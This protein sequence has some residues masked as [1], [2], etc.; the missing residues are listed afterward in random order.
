MITLVWLDKIKERLKEY[1][2]F[3]VNYGIVREFIQPLIDYGEAQEKKITEAFDKELRPLHDEQ[4]R[5]ETGCC[6]D[7][8]PTGNKCDGKL[9]YDEGLE[10]H[11]CP[12]CD[13]YDGVK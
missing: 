13:Y 6:C 11:L 2:G 10:G 4:K 7:R 9:Y 5:C 3:G 12:K 8:H 1:E